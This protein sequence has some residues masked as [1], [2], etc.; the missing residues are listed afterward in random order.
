MVVGQGIRQAGGRAD[1]PALTV[2]VTQNGQH[3]REERSKNV[4]SGE[5][6]RRQ[7]NNQRPYEIELQ[8]AGS[9]IV[10]TTE[11]VRLTP[12]VKQIV[13]RKVELPRRRSSPELLCV[14]PAQLQLEGVLVARG[15]SRAFTKTT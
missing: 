10:K 2:F 9:W 6:T 1:R 8:E 5:G 3:S 12:R 11:T 7:E 14:E 13:V 15:L 4:R